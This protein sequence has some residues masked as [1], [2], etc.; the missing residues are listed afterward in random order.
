MNTRIAALQA[1]L[2]TC[3]AMVVLRNLAPGNYR[4]W[5]CS[6]PTRPVAPAQSLVLRDV[7]IRVHGPKALDLNH[8]LTAEQA[9]QLS[10]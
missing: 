3:I 2:V 1:G 5:L 7:T 6:L 4:V 10:W 9:V 8:K